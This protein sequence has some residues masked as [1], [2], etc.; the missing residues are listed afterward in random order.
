[1]LARSTR[2]CLFGVVVAMLAGCSSGKS[3]PTPKEQAIPPPAPAPAPPRVTLGDVKSTQDA[4]AQEIA[5]LGAELKAQDAQQSFLVAEL[6]TLSEQV[7]KLKASLEEAE[8]AVRAMRATPVTPES[9]PVAPPA[10]PPGSAPAIVVAPVPPP[11]GETPPPAPGPTAAA[12]PRN[13]EA[14][15]LYAGALARLRGGED[16]QAA[17]EFTEFVT[18]FP[19]HPLAASAQNNIGEA[20]Y[21]Q[22]DYRQATAEFQKTV[23]NYT[24]ATQVSEALLKIGLS[25]RALGDLTAARATWDRVIKQF[26]KTDAARQARAL[27]ASKPGGSR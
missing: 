21:R 27:L 25:Q 13:V 24:Q 18:Q 22:R 1:M 26:P 12:S 6:K 15:R 9:R 5:R 14:E 23:D 10:P 8:S 4:Q 2:A 7:A 16:G 19:T 3:E 17:L 11:A 20:F